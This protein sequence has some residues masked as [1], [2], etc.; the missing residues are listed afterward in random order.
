MGFRSIHKTIPKTDAVDLARGKKLFSEDIRLNDPLI[1]KVKRSERP[2]AR[3]I[4]VDVGKAMEI[5]GVLGVL[6]HTDVPGEKFYGLISKDQPILA[7]DRVR[8]V[9]EA[10]ALVVAEEEEVAEQALD[11][12]DVI[13][14]DL[15]AV[16]DPERALAPDAPLIHDNGNLLHQRLIRKGDVDKALLQSHVVVKRTYQTSHLEHTYLE[17]D[18]GAGYIDQ[19]GTFVIYASTQNPHY[20]QDEVARILAVDR[21]RVRVIQAATGGG[22]G[23]KLDLNVQGYIAL[24]LYHFRRPGRLV[25]SREEAYLATPKRHPLKMEMETGA[26]KDGRLLALRARII[27]DTGA[28]AS[29]GMAVATRAAVHVTGPYKV[30][31]VDIQG[32][33][34]YTNNPVAG[35]MRGF[36]A[37]QVAFAY[38]SQ[39]DI[40]AKELGI[41]PLKLRKRNA[42][43]RGSV[44][45]TGQSLNNSVGILACLD[46]V[47]SHYEKAKQEWKRED[48]PGHVRGIGLGSMWYGIGNTASKNPAHARME[49]TPEGSV[50][51]YTGAADIGQ[52]S[53]TVLAQI[54]AEV[55]GLPPNKIKAIIADTKL[56]ANA[57]ATS[58]SRQT[59]I[60]GNA[61]K[62]AAQK[63]ADALVQQGAEILG[64]SQEDVQ[65]T[66]GFVQERKTG[67]KISIGEVARRLAKQGGRLQFDG[68]FDPQ[69]TMLDPETGQGIPYATYAFATHLAMVEVDTSTGQVFVNKII[70]AHD[71]GRAIHPQNV[72]G[73]IQGGVAM[74]IGF[75]LME[76]YIPGQTHSMADYR[77]P[78]SLDV[79]DVVSIIVEDA[80]PTGPFGAK[81]VGEPSLIPTAPAIINAIADALGKRMYVLPATPERIRKRIR[82]GS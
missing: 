78:T 34:V 50:E 36:G 72:E 64:V 10:I 17:P 29:Y 81:G 1:L 4:S 8:F 77:I 57:G 61:V 11:A 49:I 43:A 6:V 7:I 51:L 33:A 47:E 32:L 66:D 69:T 79:P 20:D 74:G 76:E 31:N 23:S 75:A 5:P 39:M 70:A 18:A 63:L 42:F 19:D 44:T 15:P 28:Y 62:D 21:S 37:P 82:E 3:L 55:L 40:L 13:Y 26:A 73:Q 54:A 67:K 58:A 35:A 56:T 9:G 53:T 25:Y 24:A 38:E 59:Y 2:H 12:I 41:D 30:D 45:A 65:L 52:G 16:F 80:E 71:V 48:S 14:E 60:S 46:A 27:C 22:F 68:Y